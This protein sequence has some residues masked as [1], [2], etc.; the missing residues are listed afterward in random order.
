MRLTHPGHFY[1][2]LQTTFRGQRL[3]RLPGFRQIP[4]EHARGG[5]E[6]GEDDIAEISIENA[7]ARFGPT[8]LLRPIGNVWKLT[9]VTKR[10]RTILERLGIS[11]PVE[12]NL[13]I[14]NP[15]V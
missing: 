3:C 13:V 14:K 5:R 10:Q 15:G 9:E 6:G 1:V 11:V 4:A 7:A 12:P 8:D 2:D